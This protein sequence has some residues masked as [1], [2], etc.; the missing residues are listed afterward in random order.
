VNYFLYRLIGPR[1]TFGP[2]DMSDD[3]AAIMGNHAGY[4]GRLLADRTAV[5]YGPVLDPAGNWGLGVVEVE[6]EA[7]VLA[8]RD[9]DPA[10]TSGLCTAEIL[11]MAVG[12]S[13]G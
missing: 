4:W 10:V 2:G 3:E 1:P 7:D 8:L 11:P 12:F 5:A 9:G 13:R 6:G